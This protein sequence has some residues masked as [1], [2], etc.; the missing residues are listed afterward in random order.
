[1]LDIWLSYNIFLR[2]LQKKKAGWFHVSTVDISKDYS[3]HALLNSKFY[4]LCIAKCLSQYSLHILPKYWLRYQDFQCYL[5]AIPAL[6]NLILLKKRK[7]KFQEKDFLNLNV[8]W[9]I[10]VYRKNIH[11]YLVSI[12]FLKWVE[13]I[14]IK[15]KQFLLAKNLTMNRKRYLIIEN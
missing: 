2:S 6:C 1:M 3:T 11:I 10:I 12:R 9:L 5:S 7:A 14:Y 4:F 13:N 15:K 8:D